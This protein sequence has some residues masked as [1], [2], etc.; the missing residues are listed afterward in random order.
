MGGLWH[1]KNSSS[2][3]NK[4][5]VNEIEMVHSLSNNGERQMTYYIKALT[6]VAKGG[7]Y[8]SEGLLPTLS[9]IA[10]R[11]CRLHWLRG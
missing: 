11:E 9:L 3:V 5:L 1:T 2:T 7:R 4:V 10:R 8:G 6:L